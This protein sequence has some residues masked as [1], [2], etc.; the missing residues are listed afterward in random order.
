MSDTS[1]SLASQGASFV[2]AP[3]V[4]RTSQGR[5]SDYVALLKPRVMTLVVFSGFSNAT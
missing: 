2:E 5:I 4:A 3:A 1:L